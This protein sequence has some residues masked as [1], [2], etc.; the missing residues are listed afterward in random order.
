MINFLK[1]TQKKAFF[2]KTNLTKFLSVL[3]FV[4]L[5]VFGGNIFA[6]SFIIDNYDIKTTFQEDWTAIVQENITANFSEEKHWIMRKIPLQYSVIWTTFQVFVNNVVVENHEYLNTNWYLDYT[7]RIWSVDKFVDWK[8]IYPISYD[9]YWLIKKFSWYQELY[10]NIVWNSR[11]TDLYNINFQINFPKE[12]DNKKTSKE[13]FFLYYGYYWEQK[14]WW[15]NYQIFTTWII[16][17]IEHLRAYQWITIWMKFQS[18]FFLLDDTMQKSL[19]VP[20][21]ESKP[22]P[23]IRSG[24]KQ[25]NRNTSSIITSIILLGYIFGIVWWSHRKIKWKKRKKRLTVVQYEPP[26]WLSASEVWVLIDDVINGK[27]ITA[28][29]YEFAWMWLVSFSSVSEWRWI[30]KDITYTLHKKTDPKKW[31]LQA[32]QEAFFNK[33]FSWEKTEFKL[34]KNDYKFTKYVNSSLNKLNKVVSKKRYNIGS[35]KTKSNKPRIWYIW[36]IIISIFILNIIFPS[37][38]INSSYFPEQILSWWVWM[39]YFAAHFI[40]FFNIFTFGTTEILNEEWKK[41]YDHIKWYKEFLEKVDKPVLKKF[42]KQDPLFFDKTLP[43]A[44]VLWV[45]SKFIKEIT[46]LMQENPAW[47]E[48]WE[49]AISALIFD[50]ISTIS[51]ASNYVAASS[52]YGWYS[53]SYSSS[54]WFSSGSSFSSS[55]SSFSGWGGGWWWGSSW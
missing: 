45:E 40:F 9:I 41:I 16:G 48:W 43:Y 37:F 18:G 53:T 12:I 15:I 11:E 17:T 46:P 39:I 49:M 23:P 38:A 26:K 35:V 52:W 27:D 4:V 19:L 10:R 50:S 33:I 20:V 2:Q 42:L 14:T 34:E 54:S 31:Q 32:F 22:E 5:F 24:F 21:Y 1:K 55:S 51:S 47:L 28:M 29:I 44:I 13:E 6:E 3:F 25:E 36:T 8:Q 30:F 7:I